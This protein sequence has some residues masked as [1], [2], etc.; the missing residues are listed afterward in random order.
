[1]NERDREIFDACIELAERCKMR[2]KLPVNMP[3]MPFFVSIFAKVG[4]H[5]G[6][7]EGAILGIILAIG[8]I[9]HLKV[10]MTYADFVLK[11][12][13]REEDVLQLI[14]YVEAEAMKTLGEDIDPLDI[15]LR[16]ITDEELLD[17]IINYFSLQMG[18]EI[19]YD[20]DLGYLSD[21]E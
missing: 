8:I 9:K 14:S 1:M 3:T 11:N 21:S 13:L 10:G 12:E 17:G 15:E 18:Y 4:F 6:R 2:V 7:F 20:D 5:L 16:H 19:Y